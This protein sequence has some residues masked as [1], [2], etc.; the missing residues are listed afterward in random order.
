L[1]V[2]GDFQ[3]C[4]EPYEESLALLRELG[5]ERG[6][7]QLTER[8][9]NSAS[10]RGELKRAE[11]LALESLEASR[12][13]FP[14][15]EVPAYTLLGQLR[16]LSGDAEG[17]TQIIRGAE[18]MA[19]D[20]G[21]D[22]W[23]AGCLGH[24]AHLALERGDIDEAERDG[25]EALRLVREAESRRGTLP[26]LTGLARAA[27]ERGELRRSGLLWGAVEAETERAPNRWW[28]SRRGELARSLLEEHDPQF[29]AGMED[30]RRLDIWEAAALALGEVEGS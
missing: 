6:I 5:D 23:R 2:L 4:D 24:L 16:V 21:W 18:A 26:P 8:L 25:H 30:G 19:A 28:Q 15:L 20:L 14:F 27:L 11:A 22:W 9:A 17:G 1:H 29:L 7:A 13:R 3:S 12:G 10:Q